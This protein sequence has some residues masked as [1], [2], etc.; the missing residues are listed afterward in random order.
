ML[1]NTMTEAEFHAAQIRGEIPW[2]CKMCGFQ[3]SASDWDEQKF[4]MYGCPGR[5]KAL[6]A[7]KAKSAARLAAGFNCGKCDG[8]GRIDAFGHRNNGKCYACNGTGKLAARKAR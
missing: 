7:A 8:R 5:A 2:T 3:C 1:T 6:E 4:H